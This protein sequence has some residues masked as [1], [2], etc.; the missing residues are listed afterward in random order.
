MF[1]RTK[2]R[3]S[4]NSIYVQIVESRKEG[5]QAR[6]TVLRHIGIAK[7]ETELESLRKIALVTM[8]RML[9]ARA[10][11]LL[12][13]ARDALVNQADLMASKD[14]CNVHQLKVNKTVTEGPQ[15]VYERI[16]DELGFS[17]IL[18]NKSGEILKKVVSTRT[19]SPESKLALSERISDSQES[20]VSVDRIY[21][22]M[23]KLS[24]K[25]D[26]VRELVRK[27][28]E[29]HMEGQID[30]VFYDCTTLYFEST[31]ADELRRFG[32]SKDHKYHQTQV[33]LAVATTGRGLPVDFQVFPGNTAETSTLVQCLERWKE[34]FPIGSV[35]FVADRG[36]FSIKNLLEIQRAGYNFIVACPL[37]KLDKGLRERILQHFSPPPSS[38]DSTEVKPKSLQ[39]SVTFSQKQKDQKTGDTIECSVTG[40]LSVDFSE[41]RAHKDA[42][43]RDRLITK[44]RSKVGKGA[45]N[46]K[47]LISNSGYK[48]FIAVRETGK[49]EI[50]EE[51]ISE[52]K[53]WD[54]IHGIFSSQCLSP[55]DI[56]ARYQH[57]WTIEETFRVAKTDLEIRP[58]FHWKKSR[59][60]AHISICYLSLAIVRHI[61][62][63]LRK[64][65]VSMSA[66]RI[67]EAVGK[68]QACILQDESSQKCFRLPAPLTDNARTILDS[69]HILYPTSATPL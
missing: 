43:D 14:K 9:E 46:P 38:G 55:E 49:V 19:E 66:R 36:L 42:S 67:G 48:K 6:Q 61:E 23:D 54:G 56:R 32:F 15:I 60:I 69:L 12:F 22:M 21:R 44:I 65:G 7:N 45:S 17:G 53:K 47:D 30:V 13:D 39:E 37:R 3:N 31:E 59:I 20:K 4:G 34:T 10:G 35:T 57:L 8:E 68:I 27:N 64:K 5:K 26:L 52:D 58:M 16:F 1:I 51:K 29:R 25:T 33:V 50:N 24:E 18:D 62:I 28:A 41:S 2:A 63:S 40:T 11:G